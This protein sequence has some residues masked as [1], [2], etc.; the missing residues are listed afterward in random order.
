MRAANRFLDDTKRQTQ[1]D[2]YKARIHWYSGCNYYDDC[3]FGSVVM[4]SIPIIL[5][6]VSA[7]YFRCFVLYW[8]FFI[9]CVYIEYWCYWGSV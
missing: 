4:A 8:C 6:G 3:R 5:G 2:L 9:L 1:R 7:D